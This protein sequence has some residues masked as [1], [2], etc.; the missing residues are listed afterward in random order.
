[1][2][3]SQGI[4]VIE[5]IAMETLCQVSHIAQS[6]IIHDI[7]D[8]DPVCKIH[9]AKSHPHSVD[10]VTDDTVALLSRVLLRT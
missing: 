10:A 4:A 3:L 8:S 2:L 1:M 6:T 9:V 7:A 5:G